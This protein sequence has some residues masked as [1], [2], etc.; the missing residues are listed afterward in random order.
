MTLGLVAV[1]LA[2]APADGPITSRDFVVDVPVGPVIGSHRVTGLAGACTSVAEGSEGADF[3]PSAYGVRVPYSLDS[4]DW[5]LHLDWL[6]LG[7]GGD[8]DFE[9]NGKDPVPGALGVIRAG[10]DVVV[11]EVGGGLSISSQEYNAQDASGALKVSSVQGLAGPGVS[12]LQSQL[13]IGVA[14]TIESLKLEHTPAEGEKQTVEYSGLTGTAGVVVRPNGQPWRAGL[15][16]TAPVRFEQ[17]EGDQ[18]RLG[19]LWLPR[20]VYRPFRL[21][22]GFS[23]RWSFGDTSYNGSWAERR[24]RSIAATDR[25]Y[26]LAALDLVVDGAS[27]AGATGLEG[28]LAQELDVAGQSATL[29]VRGGVE[30]EVWSDRM[31]LRTGAYLEPS[32][33]DGGSARVHHTLG[34]EVRLFP[35]WRWQIRAATTFDYARDYRNLLVGI[36]FWH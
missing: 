35:L 4:W 8:I 5:D 9:N 16:F 21:A 27:P 25:R 32:R 30:S 31:I 2:L 24:E 1:A 33:F 20:S 18:D 22:M 7:L 23:W 34:A 29:S 36:G 15:T 26:L 10:F 3:N 13:A 14:L 12:F 6:I 11:G 28:L 17:K 19:A